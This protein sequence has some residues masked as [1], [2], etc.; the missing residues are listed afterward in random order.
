PRFAPRRVPSSRLL[1]RKPSVPAP[2]FTF[3]ARRQRR[4]R[5]VNTGARGFPETVTQG[6][7]ALWQFMHI[8]VSFLWSAAAVSLSFLPA[9]ASRSLAVSRYAVVSFIH[10]SFSPLGGSFLPSAVP[11]STRSLVSFWTLS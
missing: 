2:V 1:G 8:P 5:N 11:R 10:D 3:R 4:A 6:L 9:A 7:C